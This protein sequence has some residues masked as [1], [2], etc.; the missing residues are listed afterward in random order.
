M[1]VYYSYNGRFLL[2][3]VILFFIVSKMFFNSFKSEI[4][5]RKVRTPKKTMIFL[6]IH[7]FAVTRF[8]RFMLVTMITG[9]LWKRNRLV[10]VNLILFLR[11]VKC[12][13]KGQVS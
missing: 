2:K 7:W 1:A 9:K 12:Y 10:T 6:K 11:E 4:D 3:H 5:S 8:T 13:A